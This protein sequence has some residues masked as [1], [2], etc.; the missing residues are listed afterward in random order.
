VVIVSLALV[1]AGLAFDP[2]NRRLQAS[3]IDRRALVP[4]L[5]HRA[6][7]GTPSL[8]ILLVANSRTVGGEVLWRNPITSTIDARSR[9]A[10]VR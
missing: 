1:A 10:L 2:G 3:K 4:P 5:R 8:K 9:P 6:P 7:T